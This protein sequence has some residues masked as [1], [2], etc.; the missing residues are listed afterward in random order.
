MDDVII[1]SNTPEDHLKR[2]KGVFEK[3]SVAGLKLKSSKHEPFRTIRN[4]WEHVV[5]KAGISTD[6]KKIQAI[7]DWATPDAV[8]D[9]WCFLRFSNYYRR[10]IPK[11]APIAKPLNALISGDNASKKNKKIEWSKECQGAFGKL[12]E[13]CTTAPVLGFAAYSKP[14][15]VHT[16][17]SGLAL[18]AVL[19]PDRRVWV[20]QGY[21]F[22]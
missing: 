21:Q 15:N 4:Y 7:K 17:A 12:K 20:G 1:F 11:S 10:F 18:G 3:L 16:D 14:I 5:S 2:L 19:L 9:V 13:L 6:P 8:T 22:C